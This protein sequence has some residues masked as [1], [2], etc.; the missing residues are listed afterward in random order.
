MEEIVLKNK[1]LSWEGW[2]VIELL[3]SKSAMFK[4]NG[5]FFQGSWYI[6]NSYVPGKHGWKIPNKYTR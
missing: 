3:P 6:K 4:T 5:V 1:T 2:N